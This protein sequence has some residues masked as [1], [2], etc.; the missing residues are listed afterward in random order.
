MEV[1]F[2]VLIRIS[3]AFSYKRIFLKIYQEVFENYFIKWPTLL[4]W[5]E[6]EERWIYVKKNFNQCFKLKILQVCMGLLTE[7]VY[8]SKL[9]STELSL[10]FCLPSVLWIT[11]LQSS[12]S[13]HCYPVPDIKL[14]YFYLPVL[15]VYHKFTLSCTFYFLF[16]IFY[17]LD[18]D[19]KIGIQ[20]RYQ[21]LYCLQTE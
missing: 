11:K 21:K 13:F 3:F 2:E 8:I 19:S 20:S 1:S 7:Y 5:I 12:S 18:T 17:I 15:L 6:T 14:F 16:S 9:D 4:N 10:Y